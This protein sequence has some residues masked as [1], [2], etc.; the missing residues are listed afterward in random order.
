MLKLRTLSID[1]IK[2]EKAPIK[3][4]KVFAIITL[5][6]LLISR[7][8]KEVLQINKKKTL[9]KIIYRRPAQKRYPNS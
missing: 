1:M 3:L 2:N 8:Y 4:K 9:N 7:I 5:G 6:K